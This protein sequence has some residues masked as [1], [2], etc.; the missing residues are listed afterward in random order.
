MKKLGKID[1]R[2]SNDQNLNSSKG[3]G[4]QKIFTICEDEI[5]WSI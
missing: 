2:S 1:Q 3:V 4:D 5:K